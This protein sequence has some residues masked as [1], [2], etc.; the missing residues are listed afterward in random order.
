MGFSGCLQPTLA[1]AGIWTTRQLGSAKVKRLKHDATTADM[2]YQ[3]HD[4]RL[5]QAP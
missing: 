5:E 1:L 3:C 2:T 4:L